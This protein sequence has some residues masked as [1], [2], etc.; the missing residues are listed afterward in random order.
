MNYRKITLFLLLAFP[1]SILGW[2]VPGWFLEADSL[3]LPTLRTALYSW[4]PAL[5]ALIVHRQLY[6]GSMRRYGWNRKYFSL[7]WIGLSVAMP[8]AI[9]LGSLGVIYLMGEW[10]HLPGFGEIVL[11]VGGQ[12]NGTLTSLYIST[13]PDLIA[14]GLPPEIGSLL[15]ILALVSIVGGATVSLLWLSGQELGWRGFMLVETRSLGFLGSNLVIGGLWGLWLFPLLLFHQTD[16]LGLEELAWQLMSTIG[17]GIAAAFPAAW[18]TI[19]SR[20]IYASAT[21]L[22]V[23][24]NLAPIALFFTYDGNPLIASPQGLAGMLVMM[25]LTFCI[26]R[27]DKQMVDRY[28]EWVF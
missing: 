4:G 7:R 17:F 23:F 18:L 24:N 16:L 14:L 21:F 3:F 11:G 22:G 8:I 1:L 20:S 19:R 15:L 2:Y 9:I 28:D 27:F 10:L 5:A 13:I 26:I 12:G 6:E 25:L